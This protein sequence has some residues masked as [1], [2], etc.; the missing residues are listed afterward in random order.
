M[1]PGSILL[2]I[3]LVCFVLAAVGEVFRWFAWV[4]DVEAICFAGT[5]TISVHGM[6]LGPFAQAM[7]D[8][9]PLPAINSRTFRLSASGVADVSAP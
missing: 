6:P 8:D 4:R 5:V 9:G 3:A 1:T 2:I 7:R